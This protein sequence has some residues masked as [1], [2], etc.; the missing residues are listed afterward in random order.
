MAN[1]VS[2]KGVYEGREERRQRAQAK[3]AR[4]RVEED[5]AQR[6]TQSDEPHDRRLARERQR[7]PHQRVEGAGAAIGQEGKAAKHRG[8]PEWQLSVA[9]G[10]QK[11]GENG[12][13]VVLDVVL[14]EGLP[15]QEKDGEETERHE[16]QHGNCPNII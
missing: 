5:A 13:V 15:P 14:V 10:I 11:M 4:K 1:V 9:E 6:R 16:E 3:R 7:H 8:S 2:G 12:E